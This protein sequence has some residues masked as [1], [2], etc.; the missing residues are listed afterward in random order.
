MS[1][2]LQTIFSN[3][4]SWIK[5]YEFHWRFHWILFLRFK[6]IT[7]QYWIRWQLGTNQATNHYLNQR[8]FVYLRIYLWLGLHDLTEANLWLQNVNNLYEVCCSP[9]TTQFMGQTVIIYFFHTT[10]FFYT[11]YAKKYVK[12]RNHEHLCYSFS[13]INFQ[14]K[15]IWRNFCNINSGMNASTHSN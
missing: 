9:N 13:S 3:K 4:F 10:Q 5:L 12:F 15:C 1:A 7:F 11:V 14:I 6:L 2:T 8:C